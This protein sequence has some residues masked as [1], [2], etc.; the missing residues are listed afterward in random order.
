MGMGFGA[1]TKAVE[2][3]ESRGSAGNFLSNIYWNDDRSGKGE[4]Y[5]KVLRFLT[6]DVIV[7]KFYEY[8][9]G[10]KPNKEGKQFRREFIDPD[11]IRHIR[12]MA[13]GDDPSDPGKWTGPL[14]FP[15]LEGKPDFFKVN[16]I[17]LKNYAGVDKLAT[18]LAAER[19]VGL[20]VLREVE[21]TRVDGK[22]RETVGDKLVKRTWT[23]KDEKEHEEEGPV[24]G[25]VRQSNKNFWGVFA[26]YFNKYDTICDRDYEI[27][28]NGNNKD[29]SYTIIPVD[30]D[31][32][33]F[34]DDREELFEKLAE[35]YSPPM[36]L[37]E[38]VLK[39]ASYEEAEKWVFWDR[40]GG[41]SSKASAEDNGS[42]DRSDDESDEERKVEPPK[43]SS[44]DELKA[45]LL[46]YQKTK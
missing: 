29:T 8:V 7:A 21:T 5:Q 25:V 44:N 20:A 28:R 10:G 18:E 37:R 33:L 13:E 41:G 43:G 31:E 30:K 27:T 24:Y 12:E 9:P 34:S 38:W 45:K 2:K 36:T 19:T 46:G 3:S 35:R 42:S 11:S 39:A 14:V 6:D 1:V 40:E 15:E 16:N 23:D 4:N 17:R 26:G 32:E 22:R